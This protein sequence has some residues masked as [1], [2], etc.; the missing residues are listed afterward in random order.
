MYKALYRKYRPRRF[1]DVVGQEAITTALQNQ[2]LADKIGHAYLFTGTRGTG[3]TTC[4][5]IFATAVNCENPTGADPCGECACCVGIE[6]GSILDVTEIDA[7]SN[8]SVD[9]VRDL[10]DETAYRPSRC[11]F[12]VYII[13]EV[14]MLSTSAFNALLK[15][16]EEP[17]SHVIFILATTEIHKVPATILSRCQRFDFVRIPAEEIAERLLQVAGEE[18]IRLTPGAA[19]LIARLADGALRDALSLLDTC[20]GMGEEVNEDLVRRMAGI[21][22]KSYLFSLSR[23]VTAGDT[24][25][26]IE[27]VAAL[28]GRSVEVKRLCEELVLHYR[29]FILALAQPDGA[30]LEPISVEEKQQYLQD[31]PQVGAA[32]AIAAVRRLT[33]ALDRMSRSPDARIEL[34]L[35]LFDLCET[36]ADR[37]AGATSAAGQPP[38]AA[39]AKPA[40]L[41]PAPAKPQLQPVS[42]AP[43]SSAT[44]SS[45][46]SPAKDT[47][48]SAP[49]AAPAAQ[50]PVAEDASSLPLQPADT[51]DVPSRDNNTRETVET[52]GIV[53]AAVEDT[54]AQTPPAQTE[55]VQAMPAPASAAADADATAER[56]PEPPVPQAEPLADDSATAD[57]PVAFAA[58]PDVVARMAGVDRMLHSY[59]KDA[60]AYT[61]GRRILIDGGDMF[62][63]FMR[64]Y[65]AANEKIKAVIFEVTGTRYGIGPYIGP[66][67]DTQAKPVT[68]QDTLRAWQEKGVPVEYDK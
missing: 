24:K 22:D 51:T 54:P 64:K 55:Q 67:Q 20:A 59:M 21:T 27:L 38:M 65:D 30:L 37:T 5:K 42:V 62:L 19:S 57:T 17:P 63:S 23:A 61:D 48:Q 56:P 26:L 9:D 40:T 58:W 7:A 1:S 13:D 44:N 68:A 32:F 45:T 8:N 10:R 4:A 39:Q 15:I 49:Q 52:K 11:R 60:A 28:R 6:N 46:G 25:Q 35:A 53:E 12:K 41:P 66:A 29:N 47:S 16:L 36:P 14:H 18:D 31:A 34:E 2:I 43:R 50:V 33:A 3:K